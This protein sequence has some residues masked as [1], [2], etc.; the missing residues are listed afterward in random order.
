MKNKTI[1]NMARSTLKEKH[2]SNEFWGEAVACSVYV[3]NKS[4]TNSLRKKF[5]QEAWTTMRCSV[6]HLRVFDCVAYDRV[7]K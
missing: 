2:L 5:P 7:P 6:A 4:R 1:M 3:L